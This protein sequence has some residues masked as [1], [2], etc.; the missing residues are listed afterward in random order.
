MSL[1][2]ASLSSQLKKAECCVSANGS[3]MASNWFYSDAFPPASC[4]CFSLLHAAALSA[5]TILQIPLL[6][7]FPPGRGFLL[8]PSLV[9][10]LPL[11]LFFLHHSP[12]SYESGFSANLTIATTFPPL[13]RLRQF[14]SFGN[15]APLTFYQPVLFLILL[16]I[17][18]LPSAFPLQFTAYITFPSDL[19]S[20]ANSPF[21]TVRLL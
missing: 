18:L 15:P 8:L 12:T 14:C 9:R 19:P 5:L 16:L 17:L 2:V 13:L 6:P 11:L 21:L 20:T 7:S 10:C 1:I 3:R 4:L